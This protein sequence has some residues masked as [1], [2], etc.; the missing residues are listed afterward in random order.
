MTERDTGSPSASPPVPDSVQVIE[1]IADHVEKDPTEVDFTFG[2]YLDPDALDT[3]LE[4]AT[5]ELVIAFTIDELLVTV[6]TDGTI[7]VREY[8]D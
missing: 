2:D 4:S 8:Q 6:A 1:R 5:S 7:D 3:L